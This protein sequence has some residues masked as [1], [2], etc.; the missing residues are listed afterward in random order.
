MLKAVLL[1]D[2]KAVRETF[3]VMVTMLEKLREGGET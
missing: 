1:P 2:L 3:N